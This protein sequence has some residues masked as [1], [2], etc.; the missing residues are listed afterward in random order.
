[1][2]NKEIALQITLKLIEAKECA[3]IGY[4]NNT[5]YGKAFAELYNGVLLNLELKD[6]DFAV[7]T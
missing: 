3:A 5:D 7:Q 4:P 1:M 2:D 6:S